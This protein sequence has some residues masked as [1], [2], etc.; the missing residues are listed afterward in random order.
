MN[1]PRLVVFDLDGTLLDTLEDLADACNFALRAAGFPLH[2]LQA[3][4]SFVGNGVLNLIRCALPEQYRDEQTVQRVRAVFDEYYAVHSADKTAPYPGIV[5]LLDLLAGQGIRAAVLSNKAD[6]YVGPMVERY[7]PGRIALS[8][9]ARP[10]MPLKPDPAALLAI[11]AAM[12]VAAAQAVY[13]GDSDI[14][15][16][17]G[18][19]AGLFTIG[20]GWGF[21]TKESLLSSGADVVFDKV[22][23]LTQF[24]VDI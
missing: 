19:A 15:V 9:G 2:N 18:K 24:L 13:V 12:D 10:D 6:K 1:H 11:L 22:E 14:D 7:F 23:H 5:P 4:K 17:T 20:V 3:I 16:Y 8:V 21:R